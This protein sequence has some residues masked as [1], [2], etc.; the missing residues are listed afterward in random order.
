MFPVALVLIR[1]NPKININASKGMWDPLEAKYWHF[2]FSVQIVQ[3][4]FDGRIHVN[5]ATFKPEGE[6]LNSSADLS[7]DKSKKPP[8][9]SSDSDR[10]FT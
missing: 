6:H 8:R 10:G 7:G 5:T 2:L 3:K 9:E 4:M 1:E